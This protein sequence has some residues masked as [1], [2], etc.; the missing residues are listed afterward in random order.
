MISSLIATEVTRDDGTRIALDDMEIAG[1]C[2]LLGG[3]GAETVTKLVGAATVLFSRHRDQWEQ[4]REDRSKIP[5]AV[6]EILRYDGPVQYDMRCTTRAVEL[7]GTAIPS[8]SAVMLLNS[9]A[10]RDERAFTFADTFDVNR[11][12]N[13]AQ[14]LAFGYGIHSCLGAA[15]ARMESRI[16]LDRLL[17]AIPDFEVDYSNLRRVAMTSVNGYSHVPVRVT[18]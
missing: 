11:D 17:D 10:N 3:A 9:A 14:N 15:L 7:H 1:F 2:V 18:R 5:A 13:E 6:E 16:A 12:R 4:L 8:G